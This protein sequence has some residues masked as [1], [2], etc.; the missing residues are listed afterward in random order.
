MREVAKIIDGK[1]VSKEIKKQLKEQIPEFE[2][3]FNKRPGL[4]VVLVGLDEASHIYVNM[5]EKACKN[6]GIISQK[7]L[8]SED[9]GQDKLLKL[10]NDLNEDKSVHGIL[11]QLPLPKHLDEEYILNNI[12]PQKDVD[13]FHPISVGRLVRGQ[14]ALVPCTPAGIIRLIESTGE[15]IEGKSAVVV[16]RSNIVGKPVASLLLAK[17]ATVTICHSRTKDLD[18]VIGQADILVAAIGKPEFVKGDWVK[19]GAT[20]IDVGVNRVADGKLVGDVEFEAAKNRAAHITPVPGGVG[21]MTIAMLL[22]NTVRAAKI[23][24]SNK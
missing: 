8:L 20:V 17:H 4:S 22:Y 23:L 14:K 24:L 9:T 6:V 1:A 11:V 16:G 18:K 10:I 5:K 19:E 13:G 2:K 21:P 12:L 15:K 3:K 7:H